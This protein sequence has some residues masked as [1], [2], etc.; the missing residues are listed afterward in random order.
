MACLV[1]P[2]ELEQFE[3]KYAAQTGS[4]TQRELKGGKRR[5]VENFA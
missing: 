2:N 4:K 1:P 5:E 3:P